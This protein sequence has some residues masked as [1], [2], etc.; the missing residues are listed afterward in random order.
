MLFPVSTRD[1]TPWELF[2]N[3]KPDVSD[4]RIFGEAYAL[5]PKELR[6]KLD[7]HSEIAR[8][9]G[10]EAHKKTYVMIWRAYLFILVNFYISFSVS[11]YRTRHGASHESYQIA[12]EVAGRMAKGSVRYG[13]NSFACLRVF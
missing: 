6:R 13:P 4:K 11:F 8:F 5:V 10:Y 7:S 12:H 3:K 2:Y 1:K 9:V